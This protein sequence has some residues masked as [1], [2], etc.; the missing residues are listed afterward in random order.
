MKNYYIILFAIVGMLGIFTSC[1]KDGDQP[2][3]SDNVIA[4]AITTMPDLTL[5]RANG[6][7]DVTFACSPVDAGFNAS[8][9]YFLEACPNGDN[10]KCG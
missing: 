10:L 6:A 3:M 8:A 2:V 1:E 7:N 9:T 5:V 4:P